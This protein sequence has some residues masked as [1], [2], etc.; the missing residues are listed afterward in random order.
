M[1]IEGLESGYGKRTV[2]RGVTMGIDQKE[3]VLLIGSNGAGKTTTIRTIFGFLKPLRGKVAYNGRTI[4]ARSPLANVMDRI[5]YTPQERFIF[6]DLSVKDNLDLGAYT[7]EDGV[8]TSLETIYRLFP[9]LRERLWQRAGTLSGGEQRMLGIGM[10]LIT[11]PNL[12]LL[13]EPSVG[14][15][16]VLV[17]AVM[18]TL[19]QI[20]ND[21]GTSILLVEQ[22]VKQALRIA[23]RVYVMKMGEII[24]EDCAENLLEKGQWWDLY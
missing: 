4:T 21:L 7:V 2:V 6:A 13:D 1:E 10:A 23:D 14:L 24:L 19:E 5:S 12:L 20:K 15:A 17:Q 3:I 18:S 9:I 11:R 22:N 8:E 16:P